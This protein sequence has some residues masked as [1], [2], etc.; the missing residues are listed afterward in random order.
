MAVALTLNL[1]SFGIPFLGY[2][3]GIA[4]RKRLFPGPDSPSFA[5]QCLLG[6]PVSLV[7]V[8]PMLPIFQSAVASSNN[9]P[10]YLITL[11]IVIEHGMIVQET[12]TKHLQNLLNKDSSSKPA[13]QSP[14]G[15][16]GPL[17]SGAA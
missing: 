16:P 2:L 5:Y 9:I 17:S 12:A 10:T 6:I 3:L 1:L 7:V 8:S 15:A 13:S 11:G 4:I 14:A